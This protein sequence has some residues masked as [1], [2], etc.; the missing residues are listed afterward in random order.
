MGITITRLLAVAVALMHLEVMV[1]MAA[2]AVAV[3]VPLI[4]LADLEEVLLETQEE[5]A[6]PVVVA[7]KVVMV[8]QILD[9]AEVEVLK[10]VNLAREAPAS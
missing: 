6:D 2:L 7:L 5:T 8:E 4:V 9:L 10:Q 3:A 1:A